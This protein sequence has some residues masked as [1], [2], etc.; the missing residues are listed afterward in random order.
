MISKTRAIV[1]KTVNYSESSVVVKMYTKQFGLKSFLIRGVRKK[2]SRISASLLQ[3]LS[4]NEVVFINKEKNQ[5]HIPREISSCCQFTSIS[6]DV[7]KSA[8]II[9]MNELV[10]RSVHEEETN[11]DLFDFL[12]KCITYIDRLPQAQG[13]LHLVF[14]LH[15]SKFLG[16]CPLGNF[17]PQT[18]YFLLQEGVFSKYKTDDDLFLDQK[19]SELLDNF[20]NATLEESA[21]FR[22]SGYIRKSLLEKIILYYQLH[23]IGVGE[24]KSLEVLSEVFHL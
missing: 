23:H 4:I 20:L 11:H 3:P 10:Y 12:A 2:H 9:F 24:I 6:F 14:A 13:N 8:Q 22:L 7:I 15:L 21:K 16:F 18:P 19:Q 17:T 1:L 5:L